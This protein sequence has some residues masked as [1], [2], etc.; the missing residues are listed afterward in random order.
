MTLTV[1]AALDDPV[2]ISIPFTTVPMLTPF[3]KQN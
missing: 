2:L 3:S 1:A